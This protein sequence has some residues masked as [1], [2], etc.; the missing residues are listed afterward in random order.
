MASVAAQA[1]VGLGVG[2]AAELV[3]AGASVVGAI[4]AQA[5][6]EAAAGGAAAG[7][8]AP[9]LAAVSVKLGWLAT[10]LKRLSEA[11]S[12]V[13]S[14]YDRARSGGS[15]G[16]GSSSEGAAASSHG[17]ARPSAAAA[18]VRAQLDET[19]LVVSRRFVPIEWVS[20]AFN[21]SLLCALWASIAVP[22]GLL[23]LGMFEGCMRLFGDGASEIGSFLNV[24]TKL[25]DP[26]YS[27]RV[28]WW[29]STVGK[30][31]PKRMM[32]RIR[33][34]LSFAPF[35]GLHAFFYFLCESS[36]APCCC[37]LLLLVSALPP[38]SRCVVAQLTDRTVRVSANRRALPAR[39]AENTRGAV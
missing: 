8:A 14:S 11:G 21:V 7:V 20:E 6:Q 9:A 38:R 18:F 24:D 37:L 32:N 35:M 31:D 28:E 26:P 5:E 2:V 10:A 19:L 4:A 29:W 33:Y 13:R 30:R 23:S 25:R 36:R 1:A 34:M 3:T 39:D 22:I 16:G 27:I 15:S 17:A 12:F